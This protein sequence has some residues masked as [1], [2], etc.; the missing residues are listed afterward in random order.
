MCLGHLKHSGLHAETR[1]AFD[2]AEL[3][4]NADVEEGEWDWPKEEREL[5]TSRAS[6]TAA[7]THLTLNFMKRKFAMC[8]F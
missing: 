8:L 7:K 5:N 3:A 4:A 6:G 2:V 1:L